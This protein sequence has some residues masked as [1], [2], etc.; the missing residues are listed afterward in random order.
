VLPVYTGGD[1]RVNSTWRMSWQLHPSDK[2][3]AML[4][5]SLLEASAAHSISELEKKW[6]KGPI[7]TQLDYSN[8]VLQ[9]L[10]TCIFCIIPCFYRRK[11][12]IRVVPGN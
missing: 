4:A 5:A 9:D 8:H 10:P 11:M 6:H 12:F 1:D 3:C 2:I 7:F